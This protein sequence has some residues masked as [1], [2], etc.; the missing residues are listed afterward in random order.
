M[1]YMVHFTKN[2]SE[3]RKKIRQWLYRFTR[4]SILKSHRKKV[5]RL[6]FLVEVFCF[7]SS[8]FLFYV[9]LLHQNVDMPLKI[10]F[11]DFFLCNSF[12]LMYIDFK[13]S[14]INCEN[15]FNRKKLLTDERLEIYVHHYKSQILVILY[16]FL[17]NKIK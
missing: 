5:R 7:S 9:S 2:P 14:I 6:H 11:V 4:K 3:N 15:L 12:Y 10:W 13:W 8:Y 1:L 17:A 16:M